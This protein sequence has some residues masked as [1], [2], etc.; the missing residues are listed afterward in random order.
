MGSTCRAHPLS[1]SEDPEQEHLCVAEL[2]AEP[3]GSFIQ[4]YFDLQV[5]R[6]NG[7]SDLS[8]RQ[9]FSPEDLSG[10]ITLRKTDD[11]ICCQ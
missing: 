9:T 10:P 2:Q 4:G 8:L 11:S 5:Q 7:P 6:T 3:G 1:A